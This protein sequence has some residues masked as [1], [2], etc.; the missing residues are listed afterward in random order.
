MKLY[1][2][3]FFDEIDSLFPRREEGGSQL[4]IELVNEFL[5]QVDGAGQSAA[6]IFILGATN[7]AEAVD[8]AVVSR[9]QLTLVVPL[10]GIR[11]RQIL[12]ERAL[13]QNRWQLTPEIDLEAISR[14]LEGKS[15]RDIQGV[16][17][18][19]GE[20]YIRRVGWES[21]RVVLTRADFEQALLPPVEVDPSAWETLILSPTLK[22]TLQRTVQR[23]LRFFRDP[24]PGVTPS[25]GMLLHGVPGTGKTQVARVLA[26][27]AGCRFIDLPLAEIRSKYIG[28]APKK[29]AQIFEQARRE[30]PAILFIDEIDALLPQRASHTPQHEIELINQFLQEL[31]GVRGGASGVFVVGATNFLE[32]VD[33]AVR[34]RL[35]KVIEIPL[36]GLTEREQMLRLF[37][38]SMPVDRGLD[39]QAI[40]R[41]LQGKSGRDIR[42][43]VSEVGQY[44]SDRLAGDEPLVIGTE[45]FLA[46]LQAK[47]PRGE[48]TWDDIILPPQT[49]QELQRLLKLVA[50][51]AHL[52]SGIQPP[53]GALLSGPPGTGKTQIARVMASV[54]GLYFKSY[55][56]GDIRSKWV[57]QS[58]RNLTDL[59]DQAR[60]NSPAILFFDEMESLFPNRGN[61]G[62]SGADLENQN[63]VNQFLQEVDGARTQ[64]GYV[65]ILGATNHPKNIDPAVRSRLQREIAVLLPEAPERLKL[66]KAKI[67][68]DWQLADDVDLEAYANDLV[69]KSGR[70]IATAIETAAQLAFDQWTD[71]A[72]VISDRHFRQAFGVTSSR[73]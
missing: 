38:K 4:E 30:A 55:G 16:V 31:D 49:K 52:P 26:K 71:G 72:L 10:P 9:L 51:Y 22:D 2:I 50:N 73:P 19:I 1:R 40:A 27:S 15:G 17:T 58:A 14:L 39:W 70:D 20:A 33:E 28:E 3:V 61:L 32:R 65:F 62:G 53:K 35:N 8:S 43:L 23:F 5:Q 13:A 60:Q 45:H 63:L 42:Q 57:G 37:A 54:A 44:A 67:H 56:P 7:R 25:K 21:D 68:S 69:G 34:S 12:L 41:L 24:L 59:F 36:P 47:A 66:L 6:G 46:V 64:A 29:L 11:E 18:R 48:L